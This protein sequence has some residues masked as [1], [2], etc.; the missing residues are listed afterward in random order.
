MYVDVFRSMV[1][2]LG[3]NI[4]GGNVCF[5]FLKG[6]VSFYVWFKVEVMMYL[7]LGGFDELEVVVFF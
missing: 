6:L 2:Y 7:L 4:N 3:V 1:D 5:C